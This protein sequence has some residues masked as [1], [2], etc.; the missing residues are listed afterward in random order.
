MN[1][2]EIL[3]SYRESLKISQEVA[4]S[5]V[6]LT[7]AA[8]QSREDGFID[9]RFPERFGLLVALGMPIEKAKEVSKSGEP[10]HPFGDGINLLSARPQP[11]T[12]T[13]KTI[14]LHDY[15]FDRPTYH[16]SKAGLRNL[17]DV[18][19]TIDH[20]C[21]K[22]WVTTDHIRAFVLLATRKIGTPLYPQ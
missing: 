20:I 14:D 10:F 1:Y 7:T 3:Q 13:D 2:N 12:E 19:R 18:L 5:I 22:K 8:Y 11:V 21:E 4:A 16:I 9:P 17:E 6:G 15:E